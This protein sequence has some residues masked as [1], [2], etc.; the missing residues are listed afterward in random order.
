MKSKLM[1]FDGVKVLT[2]KE[3]RVVVG[4]NRGYGYVEEEEMNHAAQDN[5]VF[6][7]QGG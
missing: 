2:T 6:L 3:Q 1:N 7:P 5:P 4:G